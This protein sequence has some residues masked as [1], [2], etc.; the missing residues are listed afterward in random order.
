MLK[1][2]SEDF[3]KCLIGAAEISRTELS[4]QAQFLYFQ[5]LEK[6]ELQEIQK[7]VRAH[8]ANPDTGAFMPKPSDIIKH[9]EGN[10]DS[11]ALQAWY[12]LIT[13]IER[14]GPYQTVCFDDPIIHLCVQEMGGWLDLNN[15]SDHDVPFKQNEFVK[16]YRGYLLTGYRSFPAKLIGRVESNNVSNQ[17]LPNPHIPTVVLIGN[18]EKAKD[19]L[20]RGGERQLAIA[21]GC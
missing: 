2:D 5:M 6:Y 3:F 14:V 4:S 8:L 9:I 13:A 18:K 11:Q 12:K 21:H 1:T 7:A 19:V 15:I 10:S 20:L 17:S 16:R